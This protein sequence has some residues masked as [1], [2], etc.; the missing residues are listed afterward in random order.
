[1][2]CFLLKNHTN[3]LALVNLRIITKI[4]AKTNSTKI[5]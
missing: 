3:H 2:S 1:M 5:E 4:M